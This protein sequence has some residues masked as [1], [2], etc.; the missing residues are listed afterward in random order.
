MSYRHIL[1]GYDGT[2]EGD[3]AVIAA[4]ALARRDGA[5][6][7]V[8]ATVQLERLS[9][10]ATRWGSQTSVWND[11][12]LD[13]TRA[14]LTR[15][16]AFLTLPAE[17]TVLFG[18]R[19]RALADGAREFGCDAIMLPAR[20]RRGVLRLLNRRG[21]DTLRRRASCAVLEPR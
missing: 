8:A 12:L 21:A 6:L 14:D 13:S 20:P 4:Q 7:T 16:S 5:K 1:V 15:A 10:R 9:R 3:E 11:V 17:L 18:P 2:S 19:N